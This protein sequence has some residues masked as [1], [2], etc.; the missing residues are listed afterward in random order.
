SNAEVIL[1]ALGQ[2]RQIAV[3]QIVKLACVPILL[4][5][6][7][8]FY[9][10]PGL[11]AGYTLAELMRYL[12]LAIDL[13][14]RGLPVIKFD[15]ALTAFCICAVLMTLDVGSRVETK[16]FRLAIETGTAISVWGAGVIASWPRF[17]RS[18]MR[19]LFSGD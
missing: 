3:G 1:L 5:S 2:T 13:S 8:Y 14:R 18:A 19:I 11:V 9:G 7:Y 16:Y 15:F 6:G 12:V 17:G 10:I 4:G